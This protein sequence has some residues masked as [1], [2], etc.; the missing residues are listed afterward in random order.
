MPLGGHVT[1]RRSIQISPDA[2][3]QMSIGPARFF[4]DDIRDVYDALSDFSKENAEKSG[5]GENPGVIQIRALSATADNVED[6][7]EATRAELD[8]IALILSAPS[9]RIDLSS[10]RARIIEAT[11]T[12]TVRSFAE[13]IGEFVDSRRSWLAPLRSRIFPFIAL[14]CLLAVTTYFL[15]YTPKSWGY[16]LVRV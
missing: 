1:L 9:I 2:P 14:Y 12:A 7:K 6:L 13:G 8:K 4:L 5:G 10:R 11:G 3:F 16:I 15:P